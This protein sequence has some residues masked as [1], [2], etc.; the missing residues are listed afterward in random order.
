MMNENKTLGASQQVKS[1]WVALAAG[2]AGLVLVGVAK[3]KYR[4]VGAEVSL[5]AAGSVTLYYG[6][7]FAAAKVIAASQLAS[8]V[9]LVPT[10]SDWA[11]QVSAAG[12]DIRADVL[13]GTAWVCIKY[14]EME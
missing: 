3:I 1:M 13:G 7:A 6:A 5:N 2:A 11:P 14:I 4:V 10:L 9:P 12:E 8:G